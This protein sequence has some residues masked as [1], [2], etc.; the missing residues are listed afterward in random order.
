MDGFNFLS[1]WSRHIPEG[2]SL[3]AQW[4]A[5]FADYEKK[6][7]EEA[8]ELK[9]IISGELPAGWEK[10]LPVNTYT[11]FKF[12]PRLSVNASLYCIYD[13]IVANLTFHVKNSLKHA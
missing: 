2:A 5:K 4:D 12:F 10:A 3:E 1:H 6:Y 9:S 8:L 13:F 11:M 7:K